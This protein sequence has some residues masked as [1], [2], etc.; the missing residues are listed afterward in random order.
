MDVPDNPFIIFGTIIAGIVIGVLT[1]LKKST[2]AQNAT[3][4][5]AAIISSD[6]ANEMIEAINALIAMEERHAEAME[7]I[8]EI[9]KNR[10]RHEA[11]REL[12]AKDERI[13][14]LERERIEWQGRSDREK[15]RGSS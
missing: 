3:I 9:L 10:D 4:H 8:V 5:G 6:A 7:S 12:R 14:K 15:G 13:A 2:P 1:Y 11:D